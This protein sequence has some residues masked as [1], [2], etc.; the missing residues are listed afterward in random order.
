M[1]SQTGALREAKK[2]KLR[3]LSEVLEKY[4]HEG[5]LYQQLDNHRVL[6]YSCGHRCRIAEGLAGVCKVRFNRGGKLYVP[7]GYVAALQSDPIEK[8]PFFHALPATDALSFGMLGCDYHCGYCQNWFTSQVLRDPDATA[9]AR[10][11]NAEQLLELAERERVSTITSTYNEPLITSEWAIAIFRQ[12]RE[13]GF[14]T[15]YVSNGNATPEVLDYIRPWVDL[16]KV[17][18]K[19]FRDQHYRELGGLL[20]NVL[21]TIRGLKQRGFW[22]EVV[23]LVI[24]DFNDS[25]IELREMAEFL[26]SVDPF[27]PWHLTAFHTDYKMQD[28]GN[29]SADLLVRAAAAGV[30]AGLKY[31]YVGNVPGRVGRWENTWCHN[32]GELL[33][34]RFSFHVNQVRLKSGKCPKCQI[35]IPGRW[36]S[37]RFD[38]DS[39]EI[40]RNHGFVRSLRF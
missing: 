9:P 18:L 14:L 2:L 4:T 10:L 17:D 1:S 6:C 15:S 16:Y 34:E 5:E 21:D 32:C 36:S 38:T 22:L 30:E 40:D 8:K 37:T 12:A 33:I 39:V 25:L 13:R 7:W 11:V 19:S 23:T 31:V 24:P 29:T 3:A 28:R 27:I 20:D 35:D 26:V